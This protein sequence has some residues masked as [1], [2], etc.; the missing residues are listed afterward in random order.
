MNQSISILWFIRI[1]WNDSANSKR[2]KK[3]VDWPKWYLSVIS[4][5]TSQ[6][7]NKS[8][9]GKAAHTDCPQGSIMEGNYI[10]KWRSLWSIIQN[11]LLLWTCVIFSPKKKKRTSNISGL[12]WSVLLKTLLK[13][14]ITIPVE[15]CF[16]FDP[17]HPLHKYLEKVVTFSCC[18]NKSLVLN[19][20]MACVN[21]DTKKK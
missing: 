9:E 19:L 21:E 14:M 2:D 10:E 20:E 16:W 15:M 4:P 3:Q 1:T 13:H 5:K 17:H 11:S 8:T 12:R 7:W 18:L 6:Q